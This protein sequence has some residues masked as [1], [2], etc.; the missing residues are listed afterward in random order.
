MGKKRKVKVILTAKCSRCNI[1]IINHL[2]SQIVEISVHLLNCVYTYGSFLRFLLFTIFFNLKR[3]K[4]GLISLSISDFVSRRDKL[5][6]V[7]AASTHEIGNHLH[8]TITLN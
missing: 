7:C 5:F 3:G 6:W 4:R 1:K 2:T 8:K